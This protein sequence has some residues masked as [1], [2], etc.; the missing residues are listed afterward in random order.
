MADRAEASNPPGLRQAIPVWLKI[1]LLSF[2]GPVGQ[3]ALMHRELVERRK[4]I[5]DPRF[6][7]ALNYCLLLPG[8][9]AQQLATYVGWLLHGKRGGLIAGTLFVL[10]GALLMLGI[11]L[12][13]VTWGTLPLFIAAFD[14]IKAAVMAI[15]AIAL[16]RIASRILKNPIMWVIAAASFIAIFFL[17]A[18]FPIIITAALLIGFL[19]GKFAPATFITA[20]PQHPTHPLPTTVHLRQI[21]QP[22][23][24][25]T[26]A[27]LFL[28]TTIWLAPL[29]LCAAIA[30]PH[31]LLT[32]LGTFFAKAALV[33][34][35]GAYAVLPYVG[36]QTVDVHAWIQPG[37]MIDGL[38]LAETT[39]GP[40]ILVLQFV[41]FLAAWNHPGTLPPWLIAT[42]AAAL[43]TWI[44][45]LPGFLFIFA[46]APWME[47]ARQNHRLTAALSA[48]TAA[49]VGVMLNLAVWFALHLIRPTPGNIDPFPILLATLCF[50]LMRWKNLNIPVILALAAT[51]GILRS[52]F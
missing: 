2:G 45:F 39:P 30:G 5:D 52:V 43:T 47:R 9:E 28:W 20:P 34:F 16:H 29:A 50:I 35:G 17:N 32:Q 51:I 33:T 36:Q 24:R 18:P 31:H 26:L 27:T 7:H 13:Y 12:A 14:G 8:P 48:V 19:G 3:I 44:T 25:T 42:T 4:W 1:G 38:G 46:G 11:S 10:P 37:Q 15:V 40:L 22:T 21:P 6:L 23:K 49:V 41:G